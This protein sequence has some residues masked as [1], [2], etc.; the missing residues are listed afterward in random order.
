VVSV[1]TQAR[2]GGIFQC[3]RTIIISLVETAV[4]QGVALAM[5]LRLFDRDFS[6]WPVQSG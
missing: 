3:Q 1:W 6:P 2:N 5:H 4:Y